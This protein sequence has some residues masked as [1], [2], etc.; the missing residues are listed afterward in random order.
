VIE[1]GLKGKVLVLG[2]DGKQLHGYLIPELH[3]LHDVASF[4]IPHTFPRRRADLL[5]IFDAE[6]IRRVIGWN[7][8]NRSIRD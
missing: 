6:L 3:L 1:Q 7:S 4:E 2:N 5:E 8:M